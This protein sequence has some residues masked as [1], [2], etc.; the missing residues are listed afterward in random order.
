MSSQ[1]QFFVKSTF[2]ATFRFQMQTTPRLPA[3]GLTSRPAA[4]ETLAPAEPLARA[5]LC[6]P[7]PTLKGPLYLPIIYTAPSSYL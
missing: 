1:D 3:L 2:T 7:N 5:E 6:E 4:P